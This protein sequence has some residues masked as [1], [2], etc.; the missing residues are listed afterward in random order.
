MRPLLYLIALF[1]VYFASAWLL[2]FFWISRLETEVLI[3]DVFAMFLA[4]PIVL[5]M[6]IVLLIIKLSRHL[7]K[8]IF[9]IKQFQAAA[10]WRQHFISFFITSLITIVYWVLAVPSFFFITSVMF[11][12]PWMFI[13]GPLWTQLQYYNHFLVLVV[14]MLVVTLPPLLIWRCVH[15]GFHKIMTMKVAPDSK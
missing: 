5:N 15:F 2:E 7:T 10:T 1:I 13:A 8:H 12:V 4:I 6:I 3:K 14:L 11:W 9:S